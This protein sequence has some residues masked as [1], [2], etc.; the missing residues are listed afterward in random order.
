[1]AITFASVLSA[2]GRAE[3]RTS[4]AAWHIFVILEENR[5]YEKIIGS[6]AAPNLTRLAKQY[7]VAT[8]FFAETHPSEPNYIAI[9]GGSTFRI[10]DDDAFYCEPG[11]NKIGCPNAKRAGYPP[12]TV[13]ARSLMDQL[14]AHGLM[15]K[16]YFESIPSPASK[17]VF[18]SATETMPAQL[19]AAKHNGF[20]N[21]ASVQN[22][23]H[24]AERI[25][26]FDALKA[27]LASGNVP[28]YAQIVPNQCN[29]MHGLAGINV[30]PECSFA[31]SAQ[32][33]AEGDAVADGLVRMIQNS[34]V[35][36]G[37]DNVAIVI[38]WDE[39][40]GPHSNS[41]PA[42]QGCCGFKPGDPS[43]GGGGQI[44]TIVIT[45]HGPRGIADNTPYNHYSLLRTTEDAFGI[46]EHLALANAT[47]EG[48][49]SMVALFGLK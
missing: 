21:F 37:K 10:T 43:N 30:S 13:N 6:P 12:H 32:L 18:S 39:D 38:T 27:D 34:P 29:D 9:L 23:P 16:G 42:T 14:D 2:C 24:L 25:V 46:S 47:A 28:N 22:S 8:N 3:N 26:N 44:P 4:P 19:Y 36:T 49:Q 7:G 5:P 20:M 48:V 41:D 1:M 17:V 15:W 45:N 40:D 11:S 31:N 33:I 35:W